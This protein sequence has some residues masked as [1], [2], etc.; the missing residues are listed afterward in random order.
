V[1]GGGGAAMLP[2]LEKM[3]WPSDSVLALFPR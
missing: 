3:F 2:A 1:C